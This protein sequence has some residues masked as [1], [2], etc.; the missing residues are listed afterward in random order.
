LDAHEENTLP[1]LFHSKPKVCIPAL[2]FIAA[3]PLKTPVDGFHVAEPCNDEPSENCV[4]SMTR[5][6]EINSLFLSFNN[7][8]N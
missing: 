8:D 3:I 7:C 2:S 4:P 5:R 6:V 1:I